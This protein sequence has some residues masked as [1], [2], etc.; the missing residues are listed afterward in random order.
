MNKFIYSA[1]AIAAAS[2]TSMAAEGDWLQLDQDIA[3]LSS[4]VAQGGGVDVGALI[5][6]SYRDGGSEGGWSFEDVDVWLEG[7]LEEFD[8]R[9][10]VDLDSGSAA[11]EDA[12]VRW[13]CGE[14]VGITWGQFRQRIARSANIDPENQFFIDRSLIGMRFDMFD[15]GIQVDGMHSGF[16]WALAAQNGA[17]GTGDSLM[18]T[19]HASYNI[20]N[21]VAHQESALKAGDELDAVIGV[22]YT[23]MEDDGEDAI[24]IIDAAIT[25]GQIFGTIELADGGDDAVLASAG[26]E[27]PYAV[28]VTYLLAD[29]LELGYRH[30]DRD[31]DAD[32]TKDTFGLNWLLHGQN[33]KWGINYIDDEATADELIAINLTVGKSRR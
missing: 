9:V 15:N 10:N 4:T 6:N 14:N 28:A 19:A 16:T 24:L 27:N 33:A 23:D 18:Y 13:A 25:M 12:W 29:N 1:I 11:L 7:S 30:E 22:G 8:W 20:G 5:R 2:S 31:D 32:T 3:S 21:G 26:S 17:D